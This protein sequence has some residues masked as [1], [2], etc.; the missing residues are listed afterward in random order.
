[1]KSEFNLFIDPEW[2]E[3]ENVYDSANKF[4]F[5]LNFNSEYTE[6][7]TMITCELVENSI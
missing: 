2:Q 3:I 7:F 4:F 1:M 6:I 5:S